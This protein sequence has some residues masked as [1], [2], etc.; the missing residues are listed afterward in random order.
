MHADRRISAWRV[1]VS[2]CALCANRKWRS[3]NECYFTKNNAFS[4][5]AQISGR[6]SA[7][8]N[9]PKRFLLIIDRFRLSAFLSFAQRIAIAPHKMIIACHS[10]TV[11]FIALEIMR[12]YSRYSFLF[13]VY[14]HR[15]WRI[16]KLCMDCETQTKSINIM[17]MLCMGWLGCVAVRRQRKGQ[18][19]REEERE[20]ESER[21]VGGRGREAIE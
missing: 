11:T 12:S 17:L 4:T 7:K 14:S 3:P 1:D 21:E 18:M 19:E 20:G 10:Y 6:E 9:R 8:W 16:K 5:Y 13:R 2:V 15:I